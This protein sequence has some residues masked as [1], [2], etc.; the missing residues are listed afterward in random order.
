MDEELQVTLTYDN[1]KKIIIDGVNN[2]KKRIV[3]NL[4]FG[5]ILKHLNLKAILLE[6]KKSNKNLHRDDEFS[7]EY[8][9]KIDEKISGKKK[10]DALRSR[11]M[12]K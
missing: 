5:T 10:G 12:L 2:A 6:I 4:A 7:L 9:V 1:Y 3:F 8:L 11:F